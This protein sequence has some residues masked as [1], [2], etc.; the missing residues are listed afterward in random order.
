MRKWLSAFTLIELLV[1]IAIIAILAGLLFPALARARE[2]AR[3]AS[4]RSNMKQL[5]SSYIDYQTPNGDYMPFNM[6]GGPD[7]DEDDH[8]GVNDGY[9][10]HPLAYTADYIG[11]SPG[12]VGTLTVT[13]DPQVSLALIYPLYI[14][15]LMAFACPSTA[16]VPTWT[17]YWLPSGAHHIHFGAADDPDNT[18]SDEDDVNPLA[19]AGGEHPSARNLTH[20]ST[21]YGCDDQINYRT[22]NAAHAI[23]ADMDGTSATDSEADTANHKQG[24]N[25]AYIDG[26]VQWRGTNTCSFDRYDNIWTLQPFMDNVN[27]SQEFTWMS[28]TDSNIKRTVWD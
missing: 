13:G 2:S 27:W 21:S 14:D 8:P 23:I 4:C 1:V 22:A 5:A 15:T 28:D 11:L 26:H 24:H 9:L 18:L 25:V 6:I 12:V 10:N 3:Q 17:Q 19:L 7:A 20:E 16:D